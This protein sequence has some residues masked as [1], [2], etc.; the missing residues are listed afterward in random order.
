M[1]RK[2]PVWLL[3]FANLPLGV[4]GGVALILTP[5]VLAARHVPEPRIADITTL[6]LLA[7]FLFFPIAPLLDVRFSRRA[8]AVALSILTAALTAAAVLSLG[9]LDTLGVWLLLCLIGAQLNNAAIGGWFGSV[10]AKE[11]GAVL[12]AWMTV[13]NVVGAGLTAAAGILLVRAAPMAVAAAVL[14]GMNLLP[15]V[16]FALAHP[17][18]EERRRLADSFGRF[19]RELGALFRQPS[20]LRLLL[21]FALPCASFALTNT[22]GGLGADYHASEQLV[23]AIFG[24]GIVFAGLAGSLAVPLLTRKGAPVW[25]YIGVGTTG[26]AI[27]LLNLVLPHTPA[28]FIWAAISQNVWQAAALAL[29]SAIALQSIGKDNPMAATQ[30]AL[31]VG[32]A[33]GPITYMQWLD[34]HAYGLGKLT[35]LYLT[36]GGLGM[37]ACVAMA[38]VFAWTRRRSQKMETPALESAR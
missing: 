29:V 30:F 12:G 28:V 27:T 21:L 33:T 13:A 14:G 18:V 36:D 32:A 31:L 15:L 8:Y 23:G 25:V 2:V 5:Q 16:V 7:A 4:T 17:P 38:A 9:N 20:V 22:L 37:L 6:G 24:V 35:A 1:E 11:E 19:A 10:I 26:A 34:G 3:G